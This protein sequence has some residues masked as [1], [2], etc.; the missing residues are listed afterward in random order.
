MAARERR[1]SVPI[2]ELT[3]RQIHLHLIG[4]YEDQVATLKKLEHFMADLNKSIADLESAVDNI[5]V[6]FATELLNLQ[7]AL[8][9][10]NQA[11]A[12]EQ[13]D[14]AERE[15]A[16]SDALA[17]ADAAAAAIDSQV[18]ELNSIGAA[19]EEPVEP[20]EPTVPDPNE[21]HPDNTLPGDLP[22]E[23]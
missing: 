12:D 6:R 3:D 13:L 18:G 14:D 19:P 7:N 10:A 5:N 4:L 11:L 20:E 9:T 15:Q 2:H 23:G 22:Q 16:L 8:A 17:A 1:V 21:P